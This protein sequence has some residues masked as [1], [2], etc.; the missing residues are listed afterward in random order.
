MNSGCTGSPA[1][2]GLHQGGFAVGPRSVPDE[3][4]A[5]LPLYIR[6]LPGRH[7]SCLTV[8]YTCYM[9]PGSAPGPGMRGVE[10]LGGVRPY[11][12]ALQA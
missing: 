12:T 1:R 2:A 6:F 3:K 9:G 8:F 4:S 10:R 7:Q 11:L 5:R